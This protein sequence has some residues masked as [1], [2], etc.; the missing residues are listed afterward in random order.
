MK[1]NEGK[2]QLLHLGRNNPMNCS[3]TDWVDSKGL[4]I[5]VD[6]KEKMSHQCVLAIQKAS[7]ILS[8][9]RS[10]ASRTKELILPLYSALVRHFWCIVSIAGLVGTRDLWNHKP[11]RGTLRTEW[12][13]ALIW[14]CLS[15]APSTEV[16]CCRTHAHMYGSVEPCPQGLQ[17]LN[18]HENCKNLTVL[19]G[20]ITFYSHTYSLKWFISLVKQWT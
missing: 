18:P 4:E 10:V 1:F 11:C 19:A 5:L 20:T 8:C 13:Q 9:F 16:R 12:E 6:S 15:P 17:A 2:S 14:I 7:G 3:G